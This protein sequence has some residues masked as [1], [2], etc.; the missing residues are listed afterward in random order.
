MTEW[1][2][3]AYRQCCFFNGLF[4]QTLL[5]G[6]HL[7]MKIFQILHSDIPALL[8]NQEI[9]FLSEIEHPLE[10]VEHKDIVLNKMR[11]KRSADDILT[12]VEIHRIQMYWNKD[13]E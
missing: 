13:G 12:V 7:Y 11:S 3:R 10:E 2:S 1:R 9:K 8:P 4:N 5:E 6:S